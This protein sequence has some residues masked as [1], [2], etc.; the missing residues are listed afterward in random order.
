MLLIDC[1]FGWAGQAKPRSI[2]ARIGRAESRSASRMR[3]TR[4]LPSGLRVRR[5]HRLRPISVQQP[6]DRNLL[7]EFGRLAYASL[8]SLGCL[9][10]G[11][12]KRRP[13][14]AILVEGSG[15]GCQPARHE[16][17]T[18]PGVTVSGAGSTA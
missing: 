3:P 1:K 5:A 6:P 17:S 2:A 12:L 11:T 8:R 9:D 7:S 14:F 10:R 13:N 16:Y 15:S 18:P 4:C